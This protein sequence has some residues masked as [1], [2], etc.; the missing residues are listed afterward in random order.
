MD[1]EYIKRFIKNCI[2]WRLRYYIKLQEAK[3]GIQLGDTVKQQR[4]IEENNAAF[5]KA[6]RVFDINDFKGKTVCEMG[7][8][9]Y[10]SNAFLE[11]QLGAEKEI[12]LEIADFVGV[13]RA[14]D[15]N[16]MR[17]DPKYEAV[18]ALPM[19]DTNETWGT[20]LQKIN[21][22]YS[23]NGFEG[24]GEVSDNS[25]DYVFSISV[26]EHIRKRIFSDTMKELYRFMK[27]GA[28]A[29][30][31]VD[32]KDHFGGGKN[33]LRFSEAVWEDEIHYKMDN[34]TNRITCSEMCILFEDIGFEIVGIK[35]RRFK[36]LPIH[37][38]K[39]APCFAEISDEDLLIESAVFTLR[40]P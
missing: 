13:D 8:G 28:M 26:L 12:L 34:Y 31:T 6:L 35:K 33:Q 9:Q 17:L 23:I 11:Y 3:G 27:H 18:R 16:I 36:K 20:Y 19:R 10:L 24:Y 15:Q 14:V 5:Y 4:T 40:K 30:H 22:T 7:P 37:R 25:V 21:A 39:L 1:G 2:P 32:Y 38:S 29:Y